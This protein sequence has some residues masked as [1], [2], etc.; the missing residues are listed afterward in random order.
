MFVFDVLILISFKSMLQYL[1]EIKASV[2]STDKS[3]ARSSLSFKGRKTGAEWEV[4]GHLALRLHSTFDAKQAFR[5]CV[6][7]MLS[8]TALLNLID[9]YST[10]GQTGPCLEMIV[11]MVNCLE[12]TFS[13]ETFPSPIATGIFRLVRRHGLTKVQ[14]ALVAMNV[15]ATSY[16]HITQVS[17]LYII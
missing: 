13:E 2:A 5:L 10:E 6:D 4:L 1:D 17:I 12:R 3:G 15:N 11:K 14:N 9:I 8:T 16:R 7:Q